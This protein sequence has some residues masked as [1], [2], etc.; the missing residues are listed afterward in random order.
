MAVETTGVV[1]D[2]SGTPSAFGADL[3]GIRLL[4]GHQLIPL[5]IKRAGATQTHYPTAPPATPM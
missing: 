5:V 1:G 4:T 3:G 2:D